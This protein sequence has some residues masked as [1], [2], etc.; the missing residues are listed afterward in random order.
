MGFAAG[1]A[2][3][4][5]SRSQQQDAFGFSDPREQSFV[6]HGGF[7]GVVADGV[8][9]LTHGSEASQSA[10]RS[11]LHAYHLKPASETIAAALARS[12]REANAAVLQVAGEP[13]AEG[14]GTTIAAAVLHDHALHWIAAGDSRIYLL[15]GDRL[16]R[17]TSDHTYARQLDQQ[18]AEGKISRAEAESHAERGS[19][20]SYL[21]QAEPKEVDHNTRALALMPED[22]VVVCSDG[23]YRGLDD[24]EILAAFRGEQKDGLQ[25]GCDAL[26]RLVLSKQRKGQDNLTVIALQPGER[27]R[28]IRGKR[29]GTSGRLKVYAPAALALVALSCAAGFWYERHSAG[30]TAP[31]AKP[32]PASAGNQGASSVSSAAHKVEND[33]ADKTSAIEPV[34]P[35]IAKT[36]NKKEETKKNR[37]AHSQVSKKPTPTVLPPTADR[38]TSPTSSTVEKESGSGPDSGSTKTPPESETKTNATPPTTDPTPSSAPVPDK[39]PA[40]PAASPDPDAP[41]PVPDNDK[42]N[43]RPPLASSQ[44]PSKKTQPWA[45]RFALATRAEF[46]R[47]RDGNACRS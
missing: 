7:L 12:L 11:F 8:G 20:T 26:V 38:A 46:Q 42:P 13:S 1:N 9:G 18:A 47:R 4:I 37:R 45:T 19:L 41:P 3:H 2:Q 29:E 23:F 40:R 5:G 30:S 6:A 43:R 10:V 14:A 25:Q 16:T 34:A 15:R 21:G 22:V 32:V 44:A 27:T 17:I 39:D 35:A 33:A 28:K 31:Q 24:R 36:A